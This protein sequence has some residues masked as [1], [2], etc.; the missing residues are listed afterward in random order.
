M[1]TRLLNPA[2]IPTSMDLLRLWSCRESPPSPRCA[3]SP[4]CLE[5]VSW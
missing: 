5:R 2:W 3:S 1:M 4:Q